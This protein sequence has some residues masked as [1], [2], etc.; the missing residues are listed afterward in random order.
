MPASSLATT[1]FAPLRSSCSQDTFYIAFSAARFGQGELLSR[2]VAFITPELI[3]DDPS[4]GGLA[5][6]VHRISRLLVARGF[7][8][9][10]FV[11][12]PI[13]T[14]SVSEGLV[15]HSVRDAG[16]IPW[17]VTLT[18]RL[19]VGRGTGWLSLF[20]S[21]ADAAALSDR[22]RGVESRI[23]PFEWIQGS[24]YRFPTLFLDASRRPIIIRCS[25]ARDA[26]EKVDGLGDLLHSRI[27]ARME[28]K[29]MR[30]ATAVY[31]PSQL[32]SDHFRRHHAFPVQVLRPPL[33]CRPTE[34]I[35]FLAPPRGAK[36]FV[37]FGQ[38]SRRKGFDYLLS[39]MTSARSRRPDIV[40]QVA[41]VDTDGLIAGAHPSSGGIRYLGW[42]PPDTIRRLVSRAIA[43]VLPSRIDN[44]PNT[45]IESL[46]LGTHVVTM[47]G[48]SLDELVSDGINGWI[49][50]QGDVAALSEIIVRLWDN[51]PKKEG[52][53]TTTAVFRAMEAD[54]SLDA[55]LRL[56]SNAIEDVGHSTW[57]T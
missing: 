38:I 29:A 33:P 39:A 4:S 13:D 36:Y 56:A 45:G 11:P 12:G 37:Y 20:Q 43:A 21:L 44:L 7:E 28:R 14:S 22:V 49:V 18:R 57:R 2:K 48:S 24:D 52:P 41:G 9:H 26:F 23:G 3:I 47:R 6:Y 35:P 31:A 51:P 16:V 32:V 34:D 42:V 5:T 54:V 25:W 17:F 30:D 15:I 55:L 27:Q 46:C 8:V 10:I 50:E 19:L 40:I 53:L 1:R